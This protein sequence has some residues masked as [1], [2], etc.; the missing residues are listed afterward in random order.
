MASLPSTLD[1]REVTDR[2]VAAVNTFIEGRDAGDDI[3]VMVLR[4]TEPHLAAGG[5]AP[6]SAPAVA[7]PAR[8]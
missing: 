2:I 7:V 6:N 8:S 4:V 3:T 5:A 1:A